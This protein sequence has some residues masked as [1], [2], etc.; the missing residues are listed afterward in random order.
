MLVMCRALRRSYRGLC[1]HAYFS[2][3]KCRWK[4]L[5]RLIFLYEH[6]NIKVYLFMF[7][8]NCRE[9]AAVNMRSKMYE[10]ASLDGSFSRSRDSFY[11]YL[12]I[13]K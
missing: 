1:G 12:N 8:L 3:C 4:F 7:V 9:I 6:S 13:C 5:I 11:E 2:S 10:D